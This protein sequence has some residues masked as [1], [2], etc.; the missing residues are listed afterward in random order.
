MA[1]FLEFGSHPLLT[2]PSTKEAPLQTQTMTLTMQ[3]IISGLIKQKM[4]MSEDPIFRFSC[5]LEGK[6]VSVI[7]L[8]KT[9]AF[10]EST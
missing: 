10:E 1:K 2:L 5:G 8:K 9:Q 3:A 7:I 4:G 6:I